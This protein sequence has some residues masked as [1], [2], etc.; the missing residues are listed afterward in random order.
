LDLPSE[1]RVLAAA[2][3]KAYAGGAGISEHSDRRWFT[4][5]D[6]N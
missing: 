1:H 4:W 5:I 3:I 6:G 2:A